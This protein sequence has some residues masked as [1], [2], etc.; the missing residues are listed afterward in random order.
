[1]PPSSAPPTP[2]LES[3]FD[4][5]DDDYEKGQALKKRAKTWQRNHSGRVSPSTES[6][7]EEEDQAMEGEASP[8]PKSKKSRGKQKQKGRVSTESEDD[9]EDQAME[10]EASEPKSKMSRGKQKQKQKGK[11]KAVTAE[12]EVDREEGEEDTERHKS[13]PIPAET[14]KRLNDLYNKFLQDVDGLTAE[15]GKSSTSLHEELHLVAKLPRATSA[16]NI[17]QRYFAEKT[18]ADEKEQSKPFFLAVISYGI[19]N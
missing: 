10:G 19:R 17:W 9:E 4:D 3:D 5:S 14:K 8:E 16:W 11:Q 18:P 15:C 12:V 13:G 2:I 7:D 6:E 1:L